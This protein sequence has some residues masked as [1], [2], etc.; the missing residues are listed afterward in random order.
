MNTWMGYP[1]GPIP[2][3]I[4]TRCSNQ[5][6]DT[7]NRLTLQRSPDRAPALDGLQGAIFEV[8]LP[9]DQLQVLLWPE[10]MQVGVTGVTGE[11]KGP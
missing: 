10:V 4:P 3:A 11:C 5:S 1:F 2:C 7:R 8:A 6:T 9:A